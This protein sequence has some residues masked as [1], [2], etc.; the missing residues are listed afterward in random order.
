MPLSSVLGAQSLVRPGVCTSS[1]RPASPFEGQVIYETDTD[2]I[3]SYNG[4]A[5]RFVSV[6]SSTD[7]TASTSYAPTWTSLTVGN[8]TVSF[9][10][11]R[12][13]NLVLVR[14]SLTFGSTTSVSGYIRF[15]L[16]FTSAT[17]S[18]APF[19]GD[20]TYGDA[21]VGTFVGAVIWVDASTVGLQTFNVGATYP[22]R[23][24]TSASVPF[25]WTTND[26]IFVQLVYEA[27]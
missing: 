23:V 22:S 21:G 12:I 27:A 1:T 17:Y 25:T 24:D 3:M 16:P 8:G 18:G 19:V 9:N 15:S 4:S 7:P 14:G 20:A 5:W 2:K 6:P 10:H 11:L 13:N 26:T